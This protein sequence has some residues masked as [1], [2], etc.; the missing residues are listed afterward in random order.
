MINQVI[1]RYLPHLL[2]IFLQLFYY[3]IKKKNTGKNE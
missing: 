2:S 1:A 3:A